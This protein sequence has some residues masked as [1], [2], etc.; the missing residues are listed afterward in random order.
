M[1]AIRRVTVAFYLSWLSATTVCIAMDRQE[2][3]S[4]L[5]KLT[6]EKCIR[7][8]LLSTPGESSRQEER[9]NRGGGYR[10]SYNRRHSRC[11]SRCCRY[12]GAHWRRVK[13]RNGLV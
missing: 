4:V 12:E 11:G 1:M 6:S 2:T 10:G 3:L 5:K 8:T 13:C 7:Y 9:Y